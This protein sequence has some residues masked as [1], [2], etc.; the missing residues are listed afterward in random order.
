MQ[1]ASAKGEARRAP[2]PLRARARS[3]SY[4][5]RQR[6][7]SPSECVS[8]TFSQSVWTSRCELAN[9][10]AT[11]PATR[12]NGGFARRVLDGIEQGRGEGNEGRRPL[13][14]G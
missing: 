3:A 11:R 9:L 4:S 12:E 2:M 5:G 6:G 13:D 7:R 10:C 1:P 8:P 14:P